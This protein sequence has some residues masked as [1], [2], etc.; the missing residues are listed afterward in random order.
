MPVGKLYSAEALRNDLA[1]LRRAIELL[2]PGVYEFTGKPE[3]DSL[4]QRQSALIDGAKT[5]QEFAR[6][7]APAIAAVGCGHTRLMTPND[8]WLTA[9]PKLFP[10]HLKF[11]EDKIYVDKLNE[12]AP[13]VTPGSEITDINGRPVPEITATLTS[14]IPADGF[15]HSLRRNRLGP[16]F[17]KNYGLWFG[18]PDKFEISYVPPES[19]ETRKA[20]L[21][22]ITYSEVVAQMSPNE[23]FVLEP[24]PEN[25]Q[26]EVLERDDAAVITIGSFVYYNNMDTF[27]TFVDSAFTTIHERGIENVLLDLRGNFGGDP[28]CTTHLLSY[29]TGEP[30]PYYAEVYRGYEAFAKP[31]TPAENKFEGSLYVLI[32]GGCFSSTGHLCAVLK[33]NDIGTFVGVETGGTFTCTDAST[34]F[35]LNNSKLRASI[36]RKRYTTAVEGMAMDSGIVPDYPVAVRI[37]DVL[38]G[39]DPALETALSMA[40]GGKE[41]AREARHRAMPTH[42][43]D[44]QNSGSGLV[45]LIETDLRDHGI[46]AILVVQHNHRFICSPIQRPGAWNTRQPAGLSTYEQS[47]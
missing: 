10:L 23:R 14:I 3:F 27:Y 20:S 32:D 45:C 35:H 30:V 7:A 16:A 43:I 44:L 29:L 42:E 36:A 22:G 15:N 1:Q 5:L 39:R 41:I 26:F 17:A 47:N 46:D 19:G 13:G 21:D 38:D 34:R 6:I 18:F 31:I 2:H 4:W 28:F 40:R 37:G 12:S 24:G 9:P 11:I 25:L 33:H 8:Y